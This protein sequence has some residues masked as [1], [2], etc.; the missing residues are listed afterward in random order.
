[1]NQMIDDFLLSAARRREAEK[2]QMDEGETL[3]L[4]LLEAERSKPVLYVYTCKFNLLCFVVLFHDELMMNS[5]HVISV[6]ASIPS[7]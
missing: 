3:E 7:E 4:F 1:M 2:E 6:I 5:Y